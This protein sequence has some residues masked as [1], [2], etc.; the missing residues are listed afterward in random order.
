MEKQGATTV[1]LKVSDTSILYQEKV[2]Q[3]TIMDQPPAIGVEK[4][5]SYFAL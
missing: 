2:L 1:I 5:P 3:Y 4:H